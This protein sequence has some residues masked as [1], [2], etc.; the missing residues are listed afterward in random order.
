M[1]PCLIAC[2]SSAHAKDFIA[3]IEPLYWQV[4]ET[5]DW[6]LSNN[7]SSNN[8]QITYSNASFDF[9]PGLR[10]SATY[11][12]TWDYKLAYTTMY[13]KTSSS[14]SGNLVATFMGGKMVQNN[15]FFYNFGHLDF[16]INYNVIDFD[17]GKEYFFRKRFSYRPYIGL[18]VGWI[19]QTLNTNLQGTTSAL[20][21]INNDFSGIGPR[22][23]F[24][25]KWKLFKARD[26]NTYGFL[27]FSMAYLA[28]KWNI[29]DVV[30]A[31]NG[32]N[33]YTNTT[34]RYFGAPVMQ[35]IIGFNFDYKNCIFGIGYELSDWFNQLQ[36]FSDASG[37]QNND[38]VL[39][40]LTLQI[41]YLF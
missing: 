38:L 10:I 24:A 5:V 25:S 4:N 18:R 32:A 15:S 21:N 12:D 31:S 7:M 14:V 36:I 40:G 9:R 27:D 6:V 16:K 35:G 17:L 26:I 13:A 34:H 19:Y 22:I 1:I 33:L 23:G 30:M 41:T 8:Q 37:A 11:R 3:T 20:E 2:A 39:Q 29:S 28:G